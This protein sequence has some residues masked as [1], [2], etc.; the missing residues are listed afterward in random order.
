MKTVSK[1][2]LLAGLI[3]A[4][5]ALNAKTPEQA[6]VESFQGR[7][8]MPVPISV[9]SPVI[10]HRHAGRT[11]VVEFI[12]DGSGVPREI[13]LRHGAEMPATLAEPI[14]T[15]LAQWRFTPLVRAG[16]AVAVR[17]AVPI[18]IHAELAPQGMIATR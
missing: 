6:Y 12:V 5:F 10:A 13:A 4:P 7:S 1:L 8:D 2:I 14:V 11:I 18:T 3:G 15:A 17:M 9:V 16:A